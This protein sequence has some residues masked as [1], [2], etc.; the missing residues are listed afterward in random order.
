MTGQ[1]HL[2]PEFERSWVNVKI[3][4]NYLVA[5]TSAT[6]FNKLQPSDQ[7]TILPVVPSHITRLTIAQNRRLS[8]ELL[9]GRTT[10]SRIAFSR[11]SFVDQHLLG[12]VGHYGSAVLTV[13]TRESEFGYRTNLLAYQGES[14]TDSWHVELAELLPPLDKNSVLA[15]VI[16]DEDLLVLAAT[17]GQFRFAVYK[18]RLPRALLAKTLPLPIEQEG[19]ADAFYVPGPSESNEQTRTIRPTVSY[20][21]SSPEEE[22]NSLTN[23]PEKRFANR[24]SSSPEE[25]RNPFRNQPE[26]KSNSEFATTTAEE[27]LIVLTATIGRFRFAVYKIRLPESFPAETLPWTITRD[28]DV[29]A[30]NALGLSE[31]EQQGMDGKGKNALNSEWDQESLDSSGSESRYNSPSSD[32]E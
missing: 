1:F 5:S 13:E 10:T 20:R 24:A 7:V 8:T 18:I 14:Q 9:H 6:F 16:T 22:Q 3:G 11:S 30:L 12:V 32:D 31:L 28:P 4:T 29:D 19:H 2:N 25:E 26:K 23:L 15:L 21:S 27:D 17:I